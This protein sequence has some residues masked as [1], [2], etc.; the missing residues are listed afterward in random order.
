MGPGLFFVYITINVFVVLNMLIAIISDAYAEVS[1]EI[2]HMPN[3]RLG[4]EISHAI[5]HKIYHILDHIPGAQ[6]CIHWLQKWK[7]RS[8]KK[9]Q[10]DRARRGNKTSSLGGVEAFQ[11]RVGRIAYELENKIDTEIAKEEENEK[12]MEDDQN[13]AS[14]KAMVKMEARL[15]KIEQM[16]CKVAGVAYVEAEFEED[17]AAAD[18]TTKTP[19]TTT[20]ELP[21]FVRSSRRSSSDRGGGLRVPSNSV[22][23][24]HDLATMMSMGFPEQASRRSL[25]TAG[26]NLMH[27]MNILLAEGSV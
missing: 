11:H 1:L 3:V 15:K 25:E 9:L 27:A 10:M 5:K 4:R 24:D 17:A 6:K 14:A 26:G 13:T 19:T 16:L 21:P 20:I 12:Q 8:S 22:V 23:S 7:L 18:T 2:K